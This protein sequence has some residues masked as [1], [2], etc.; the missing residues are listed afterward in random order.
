M[1]FY[2]TLKLIREHQPCTEGYKKLRRALGKGWGADR[3]IPLARILDTNGVSDALW[4]FRAVPDIQKEERDRICLL[5]AAD[6]AEHVLPL[7]KKALPGDDR[8]RQVI[9]AMRDF[10]AGKIA[11]GDV[12]AAARAA[13]GSGY[14]A[15]GAAHNIGDPP[16]AAI[17]AAGTAARAVARA[18]AADDCDYADGYEIAW[19]AAREWQKGVFRKY[20]E[21]GFSAHTRR[22][23]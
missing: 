8:P 23:G 12:Q 10:A 11:I 20:L 6:F 3:K 9:Q 1:N 16:A 15:Y 7:F 22:D 2:T 19:A 13:Y 17:V 14:A 5:L 4:A 18:A 21:G